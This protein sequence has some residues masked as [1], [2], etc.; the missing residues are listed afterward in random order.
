[1]KVLFLAEPFKVEPLGLGYLAGALKKQH[2]EVELLQLNN[3]GWLDEIGII[4]PDIIACS[5]TT[6]KHGRF[7][8]AAKQIKSRYRIPVVF[9]GSHPTYF[10]EV[11]LSPYVDIIVRG[12][13]DKS[14][15]EMLNELLVNK[16]C[17]S[18]VEFRTLEQNIDKLP[19]PDRAFLYKYPENRNN[20][21]KNVITSRGCRFS[22]PYCFNSLYRDF[23]KGENW[24][25]FRS[26]DNVIKECQELKSY[27]LKLIFFQDDEFLSNPHIEEFLDLYRYKVGVPFH[28]QVRIELLTEE[29]AIGLKLAGCTG[30][31]YAIESGDER[32]RKDVL[33]RN[34]TD[35]QILK[36]AEILHKHGIKSR[37]ENMIGIPGESLNQMI[38]TVNL[39]AK[40][41]P[42][43]GWSSIFQPYPRLPFSE[44]AKK[45][46]FWDGRSD[47]GETFFENTVL[48]TPIKKEIIN[49]QRLFGLAVSNSIVR[50]SIRK[51]IKLPNNRVFDKVHRVFKQ[52]RYNAL[53]V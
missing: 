36:G 40:A 32:L 29:L 22:C 33:K 10:P 1:M 12:E 42:T 9:G 49:L 43:I 15:P 21:I 14:F 4:K 25:R 3:N 8:E 41:K 35:K 30:I 46:G 52:R 2:Y 45:Y 17:K 20:P 37:T 53:F 39:N 24:V 27:P 16:K 28:C 51:L 7:I 31:T 23:Y 19:F 34:V 38:E 13:A 5:V 48:D 26:P 6:G 44:Y 18:I 47:Y 11:S 50:K